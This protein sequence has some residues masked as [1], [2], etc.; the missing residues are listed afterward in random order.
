MSSFVYLK[1]Q[2]KAAP[3]ISGGGIKTL[4][5]LFCHC[6]EFGNSQPELRLTFYFGNIS[7]ANAQVLT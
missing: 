7:V 2:L 4:S 1:L 3:E 6:L 5:A